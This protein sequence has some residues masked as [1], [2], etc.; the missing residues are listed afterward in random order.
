[1]FEFFSISQLSGWSS[2]SA[3]KNKKTNVHLRNF[4]GWYWGVKL[5]CIPNF[6]QI[7]TEVIHYEKFLAG[8]AGL[9][10]RIPQKTV[11]AQHI[12]M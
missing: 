11:A 7:G 12:N 6:S 9:H 8:R 1:M 10:C 4:S 3:K 5:T 2:C